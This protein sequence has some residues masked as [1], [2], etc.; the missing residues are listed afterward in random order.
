MNILCEKFSCFVLFRVGWPSQNNIKTLFLRHIAS[1][2]GQFN[3]FLWFNINKAMVQVNLI[4]FY[5]SMKSSCEIHQLKQ[6]S[7]LKVAALWI[8]ILNEKCLQKD[9][10]GDDVN[11][12]VITKKRIKYFLIFGN[13]FNSLLNQKTR[14]EFDALI[15]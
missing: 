15:V 4:A 14:F 12:C 11:D 2:S 8:F 13:C 10:F 7:W 1:H 5:D 3:K 6:L 9:D